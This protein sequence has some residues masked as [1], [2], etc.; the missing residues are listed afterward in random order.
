MKSYE[1]L[2]INS[3]HKIYKYASFLLPMCDYIKKLLKQISD[4][5]NVAIYVVF[6]LLALSVTYIFQG[7]IT[8]HPKISIKLDP[9]AG[10]A[11]RL[12]IVNEGDKATE[13]MQIRLL[14]DNSTGGCILGIDGAERLLFNE[15]KRDFTE[16]Y[17]VPPYS[18][19]WIVT[20]FEL[21]P[22]VEI[23]FICLKTAP[24][25]VRI[26]GSNFGEIRYTQNNFN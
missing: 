1:T 15:T 20:N 16:E 24:S 2:Y 7:Y 9:N 6:F 21:N 22:G 4:P 23:S 26:S 11:Y 3:P 17:D 14:Y 18:K 10:Q 25:E 8:P 13:N 12:R 19:K 5:K